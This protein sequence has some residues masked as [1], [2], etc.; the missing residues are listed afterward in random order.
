MQIRFEEVRPG[1]L[2]WYASLCYQWFPSTRPVVEEQP[3]S[4]V[5]SFM[6]RHSFAKPSL[7]TI[8]FSL[9]LLYIPV[10]LFLLFRRCFPWTLSFDWPKARVVSAAVPTT[11]RPE[12]DLPPRQASSLPR[13]SNASVSESSWATTACETLVDQL[14]YPDGDFLRFYGE[15]QD[16]EK[17]LTAS[18]CTK[19]LQ[20][21]M[22]SGKLKKAA[23]QRGGVE[24]RTKNANGD[25]Q[26]LYVMAK[27]C[28]GKM[29][30]PPMISPW[31]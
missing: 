3:D 12:S 2:P 24:W 31:Y 6:R 21:P 23:R 22:T 25:Q 28:Q 20:W 19:L 8:V 18:Y 16:K 30:L 15:D 9:C 10:S 29:T 11:R 1:E 7:N 17:I 14:E 5:L 4:S 27:H 13:P 26:N